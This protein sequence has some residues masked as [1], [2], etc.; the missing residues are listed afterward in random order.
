MQKQIYITY[1][2]WLYS[3]FFIGSPCIRG[4]QGI[5]KINTD[6][7]NINNISTQAGIFAVYFNK[8]NC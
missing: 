2:G 8:I 7:M 5:E 1:R 6:R 3:P 4:A